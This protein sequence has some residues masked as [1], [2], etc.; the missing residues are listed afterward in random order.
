MFWRILLGAST[1]MLA[2]SLLAV[3]FTATSTAAVW[4]CTPA[5]RSRPLDASASGDYIDRALLSV[6]ACSL[7]FLPPAAIPGSP[8]AAGLQCIAQVEDPNTLSGATILRSS[9]GEVIVACRGSANLKN[10]QT[11]FEVGPVALQTQSGP[12]PAAKVHSGFQKAARELWR[13]IEPELP[14]GRLMVT[15]HSLGGGTA[16]LVGLRAH[17]A[18][19]ELDLI[20]VAGPRL[21]NGAFASHFRETCGAATHLVHDEDEVLQSN[22]ELWDRLGFEHVG[23]VVRCSKDRPCVY[24][25]AGEEAFLSEVGI[26]PDQ[27]SIKG[28]LVDHCQYLG[29]Y[30]GV[31]AEHPS[32][33]LRNPFV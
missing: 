24:D 17:E 32:V 18:G 12:H 4:S 22:V 16:T 33:W 15:G 27:V 14:P 20:T 6:R 25:G 26:R 8:Y 30:V 28:V 3:S 2:S 11:N 7:A 5:S 19:R 21:G 1:I 9:D 31:R 10:F 13:L 23:A 29:I